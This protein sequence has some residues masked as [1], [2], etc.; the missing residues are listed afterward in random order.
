MPEFP[1]PAE[2]RRIIQFGWEVKDGPNGYKVLAYHNVSGVRTE[3]P[4][5]PTG[6][7][8]LCRSMFPSDPEERK[9]LANELLGGTII[10]P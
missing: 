4:F 5:D 9:T 8:A 2:M 7:L 3:L 6:Q 10:I 1:S